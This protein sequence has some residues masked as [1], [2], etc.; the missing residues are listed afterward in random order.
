MFLTPEQIAQR[1]T[2]LLRWKQLCV[3]RVVWETFS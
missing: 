1:P 2:S 3:Q